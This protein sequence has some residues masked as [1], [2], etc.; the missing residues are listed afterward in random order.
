LIKV[1]VVDDEIPSQKEL[2]HIIGRH[3]DFIV[4]G[5]AESGRVALSLIDKLNPQVVFL[6]IQLYDIS[7]IELAVKISAEKKDIIIIF[8]TAFDEFAVKAYELDAFDY[9]VK[10]FDECRI[11]KT[12]ER[13]RQK[14]KIKP[15]TEYLE[16][17]T[18]QLPLSRVCA[19]AD[20]RWTVVDCSDI[21]YITVEGKR[22]HIKLNRDMLT[23]SRTLH[24]LSEQLDPRE[25]LRIHRAYVVNL[26]H[27]REVIPWFNGSYNLVMNDEQKS[28]IPVSRH[29]AR[30]LKQRLGLTANHA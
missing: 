5:T 22:A 23:I 11:D 9:V 15:E 24:E 28:E 2:T 29:Y 13:V 10:P 18:C 1:L 12:L 6:D 21:V 4:A 19:Q 27:I 16:I 7:G 14:L 26:C 30:G 25:F 8:A 17:N 3:A 20:G